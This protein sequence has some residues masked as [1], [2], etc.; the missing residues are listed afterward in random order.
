MPGLPGFF[1]IAGSGINLMAGGVDRTNRNNT[2]A[3][4]QIQF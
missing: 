2:D 4:V 3:P 1:L